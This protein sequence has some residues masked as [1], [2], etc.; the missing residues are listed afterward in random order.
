MKSKYSVTYMNSIKDG[1][2]KFCD[3]GNQAIKR[4]GGGWICQRC[5]D[6]EKRRYYDFACEAIKTMLTTDNAHIYKYSDRQV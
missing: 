6:L 5:K 2:K 4:E 3:C 1:K